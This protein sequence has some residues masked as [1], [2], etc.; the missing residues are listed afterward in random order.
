MVNTIRILLFTIQAESQGHSHLYNSTVNRPIGTYSVP[1]V[2][3]GIRNIKMNMLPLPS[4][5]VHIMGI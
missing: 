1:D 4:Q 2:V 3:Q 5:V